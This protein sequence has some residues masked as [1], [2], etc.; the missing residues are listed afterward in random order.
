MQ[1]RRWHAPFWLLPLLVIL[2]AMLLVMLTPTAHAAKP[3][4]VRCSD[5]LRVNPGWASPSSYE[6][7]IDREVQVLTEPVLESF[8]GNDALWSCLYVKPTRKGK[9]GIH[10]AGVLVRAYIEMTGT[11]S[12][13]EFWAFEQQQSSLLGPRRLG[14]SYV[15]EGFQA[16]AIVNLTSGSGWYTIQ[17]HWET[18][19]SIW[20]GLGNYKYGEP[21]GTDRLTIGSTYRITQL[22]ITY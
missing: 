6:G 3:G 17:T 9:W 13:G 14:Y 4:P 18:D 21:E 11:N 19:G 8:T 20:L 22:E 10:P 16:P 2:L 12:N 15:P 1:P 5:D 7:M